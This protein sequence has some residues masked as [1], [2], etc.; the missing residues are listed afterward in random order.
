MSKKIEQIEFVNRA[1][2]K[3]LKYN[4]ELKKAIL[5]QID[6]YKDKIYWRLLV[7]WVVLLAVCWIL[8]VFNINAVI[9][10]IIFSMFLIFFLLDIVDNLDERPKIIDIFFYLKKFPDVSY[11][12]VEELEEILKLE[13]TASFM[14][15]YKESIEEV[16]IKTKVSRTDTICLKIE[17]VYVEPE[18]NNIKKITFKNY[19]EKDNYEYV[20]G[21]NIPSVDVYGRKLRLPEKYMDYS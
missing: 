16:K 4:I 12:E 10:S 3:D 8:P 17:M 15:Q 6:D 1:N 21:M 11:N 20:R 7:V 13:E 14:E 2:I 18:T 5:E 9:L 19:F